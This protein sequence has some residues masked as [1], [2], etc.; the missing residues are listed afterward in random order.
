MRAWV[1]WLGVALVLLTTPIQA[2]KFSGLD[3]KALPGATRYERCLALAKRDPRDTVSLA[4]AWHA[5]G[6]S[7]GALHCAAMALVGLRRYADAAEKLDEAARDATAGG[8]ELRAELYDQAGNAWLLAAEPQKAETSLSAGLALAPGDS[9]IRFDR[10]R[11]RAAHK[12]W[13]GADFG[14]VRS[15]RG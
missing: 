9:E 2:Q 7:G 14:S 13:A 3:D 8:A 4:E 11:A 1:P 15:A 12:V 5:S 10:A 6:G